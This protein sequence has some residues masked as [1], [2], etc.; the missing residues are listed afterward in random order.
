[1]SSQEVEW[2]EGRTKCLDNLRQKKDLRR[3]FVGDAGD[4]AHGK[5]C[6]N[7]TGLSSLVIEEDMT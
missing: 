5:F 7:G 6:L 3:G 2:M 4:P 1:M